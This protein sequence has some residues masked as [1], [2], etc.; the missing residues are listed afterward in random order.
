MKPSFLQTCFTAAGCTRTFVIMLARRIIPFLRQAPQ[1][2]KPFKP[3][4]LQYAPPLHTTGS[5]NRS[6]PLLLGTQRSRNYEAIY[7]LK[8]SL[9]MSWNSAYI[10]IYMCWNSAHIWAGNS[11]YIWAYIWAEVQPIYVLQCNLYISLNMCWNSTCI[12]AE[13]QPIYVLKF[14]LYMITNPTYVWAEI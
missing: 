7:E 10:Y 11:N 14:S 4:S 5:G 6:L 13:I 2:V 3:P 1:C 12:W 8:F 9:Y